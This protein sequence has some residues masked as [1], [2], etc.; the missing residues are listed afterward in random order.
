MLNP[1]YSLDEHAEEL[2]TRAEDMFRDFVPDDDLYHGRRAQIER[3]TADLCRLRQDR[4]IAE[5]AAPRAQTPARPEPPER[6]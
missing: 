5:A 1:A 2:L 3:W 4:L 6:D